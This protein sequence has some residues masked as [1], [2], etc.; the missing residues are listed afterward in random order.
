MYT[1]CAGECWKIETALNTS[2]AFPGSPWL[3]T[4]NSR[5]DHEDEYGSGFGRGGLGQHGGVPVGFWDDMPWGN[6]SEHLQTTFLVTGMVPN[7]GLLGG[8]GKM[9]KLQALAKAKKEAAERKAQEIGAP[10]EQ[11]VAASLLSK[12]S[13][14]APQGAQASP[15]PSTFSMSS[16]RSALSTP[17][18]AGTTSVAPTLLSTPTQKPPSATSKLS[19]LRN[20]PSTMGPSTSKTTG[21]PSKPAESAESILAAQEMA[22]KKEEELAK[23]KEEEAKK[24]K[25][26]ED[27]ERRQRE[28]RDW[29]VINKHVSDWMSTQVSEVKLLPPSP[30]AAV[31]EG[32][33][34][35]PQR[36]ANNA[37]LKVAEY[38]PEVAAEMKKNFS[39]PSPDD[40]VLIAQGKMKG[41]LPG[42]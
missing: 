7:G 15:G 1:N 4:K 39:Q 37:P 13:K 24:K 27:E 11:T 36:Y 10:Q 19:Q 29:A 17:S 14:N 3:S 21:T 6:V 20:K 2:L 41:K 33:W 30:F 8:S 5:N 25:E 42:A 40:I 28:E 9:S 18:E 16:L 31:L 32:V 35:K 12:L 26:A 34:N 23:E 38:P 22:K